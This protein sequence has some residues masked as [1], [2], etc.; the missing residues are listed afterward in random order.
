MANADHWIQSSTGGYATVLVRKTI[1]QQV[2]SSTVLVDDNEL[3]FPVLAGEVWTFDA[4]VNARST[5]AAPDFRCAWSIPS[6]TGFVGGNGGALASAGNQFG[7]AFPI[8]AGPNAE[9][10][11][12]YAINANGWCAVH[13][14]GMVL[15]GGVG[16]NV[17]FRFAQFNVSVTPVICN[18]GSYIRAFRIS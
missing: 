4:L 14:D 18:I 9:I 17:R 1:D 16:G 10:Q 12:S 11:A 3:F 6:G 2:V 7:G 5:S 8:G 13:W 15:V